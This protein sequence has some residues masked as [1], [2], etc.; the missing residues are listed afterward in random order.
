MATQREVE[1]FLAEFHIK[2]KIWKVLYRDDRGKNTQALANL[3]LRPNDRTKILEK[4]KPTDYAD[5][6]LAENL[7]FGSD[8]WIFGKDIKSREVYI[9]ITLGATDREVICIS[10][11]I[12]EHPMNYPLK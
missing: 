10:F 3:E 11:H 12:A 6:P 5:G 4:L 2:M 9:K 1:A 8:M 7:N